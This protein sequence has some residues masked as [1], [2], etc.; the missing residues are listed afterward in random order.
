MLVSQDNPRIETFRRQ[1]D[2]HWIYSVA[3][4]LD[5]SVRVEVI[6]CELAL[7]DVYEGV[8]GTED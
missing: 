8:F 5:A 3:E 4:A 2:R 6:A 7:A 1:D